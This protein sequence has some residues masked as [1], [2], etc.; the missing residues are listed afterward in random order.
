MIDFVKKNKDVSAGY[1]Y[2]IEFDG[3]YKIGKTLTYVD[4]FYEYTKFYAEPTVI[5]CELVEN[6]SKVEF[7][8]HSIFLEKNIRGEW[9]DL[10]ENDLKV[11]ERYLAINKVSP[12]V[13]PKI[14]REKNNEPTKLGD[15]RNKKMSMTR[16]NGRYIKA[17][18]KEQQII[19]M[20]QQY[21]ATYV[22]LGIM[23]S[24]LMP[25]FNILVKNNMKYGATKL[26]KDMG[27]SRQASGMHIKKLKELNIIADVD[28]GRKGKYLAINPY[29]YLAGDYV[30]FEI[31]KLFDKKMGIRTE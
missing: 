10:N 6:Y 26:A 24:Y 28:L 23:K 22:A 5:F 4:R 15:F 30:P 16:V 11:I 21:P 20:L 12:L 27:I 7:E 19:Y 13:E 29:C 18:P 2:V 1:V 17:M 14:E 8:L 31:L 9:F 25:N 3:H